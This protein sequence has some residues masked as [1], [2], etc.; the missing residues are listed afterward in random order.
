MIKA[1]AAALLN[2]LFSYQNPISK[3]AIAGFYYFKSF[4]SFIENAFKTILDDDQL[5]GK[6]YISSVLNQLILSGLSV[7]SSDIP[8]SNYLSL[9]SKQKIKEFDA[10]LT[11]Q[12][13]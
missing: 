13:I 12:K 10:Y 8:A 2:S 3:N 1:L 6:F 4:N 9:Y 5:E 7:S 11:K